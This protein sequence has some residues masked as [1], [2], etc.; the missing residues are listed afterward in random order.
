[1]SEPGPLVLASGA[2]ASF[3]DSE[4]GEIVCECRNHTDEENLVSQCFKAQRT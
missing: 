3:N 2:S 1:V 4:D